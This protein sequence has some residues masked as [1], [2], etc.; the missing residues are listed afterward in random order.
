MKARSEWRDSAWDRLSMLL[1][2]EWMLAGELF[3]EVRTLIPL[4]LAMR[5]AQRQ[6]HEQECPVDVAQ[7]L[8]FSQGMR[9]G[10]G[11][12]VARR[13][14]DT[15]SKRPSWRYHDRIRLA[16]V[17]GMICPKCHC[18]SMIASRIASIGRNAERK[19]Y[20]ERCDHPQLV[21]QAWSRLNAPKPVPTPAP[22]L[23]TSALPAPAP[24][25]TPVAIPGLADIN[26]AAKELMP[27]PPTHLTMHQAVP[28]SN[29]QKRSVA[30]ILRSILPNRY[31]VSINQIDK[32]LAAANG[33][34]GLVLEKHG[35]NPQQ[36]TTLVNRSKIMQLIYRTMGA[37]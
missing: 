5:Q 13:P 30:R 26:P 36:Q 34:V 12:N 24:L 2:G 17:E 37:I 18:E 7:W 19:H 16:H 11:I 29:G 27:E 33:N 14:C 21:T 4:H 3:D 10:K 32:E 9:T 23:P 25:P 6:R 28:M 8:M 20:C 31:A 35:F 22:A 15:K 1:P